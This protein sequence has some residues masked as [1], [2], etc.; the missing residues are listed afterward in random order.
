M[1]KIAGILS[2][3]LLLSISLTAVTLQDCLE[4]LRQSSPLSS[5]IQAAD[6]QQEYKEKALH[7]AYY[8]SLFLGADAGLNSEV[9]EMVLDTTLPVKLPTPDK[10]RE[11]VGLE[12]RQ[13]LWDNGMIKGQKKI[14]SLES[15]A[16]VL[17]YQASLN[18]A[19]LEVINQYYTVISLELSLAATRLHLQNQ[20]SRLRVIEAGLTDGVRERADL[21]LLQNELLSIEDKIDSLE[22]QKQAAVQRLS[23]LSGLELLPEM[24]YTVPQLAQPS[25]DELHRPELEKLNTLAEM[26]RENAKIATR[27]NMP[28]ISARLSGAYGKPGFNMFSTE[29]HTYYSVGVMFSWKI[30]DWGQRNNEGKTAKSEAEQL[31]RTRDNLELNIRNELVALD[32]EARHLQESLKNT[33]QRLLLL[34]QVQ[35]IFEDKYTS[36]T[37]STTELLIQSN[38]L[39]GAR[40]E[41]LVGQTKLS[42]L[43][44]RKTYI[45][46]DKI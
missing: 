38:S 29:F 8:P 22:G 15:K 39:L 40:L 43:A 30:W 37:L 32:S 18:A 9:T 35:Q 27:K 41:L 44:A 34:E 11:A 31:E 26:Q 5:N 7:S 14:S 12:L 1:K 17:D 23:N 3:F 13:L 16:K 4:G 6:L 28:Q 33:E 19:E 45:M 21:L 42:A 10:D 2:G 25:S 46:G 36:G 20:N 24:E